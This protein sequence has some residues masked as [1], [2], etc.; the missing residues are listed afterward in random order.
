MDG[1]FVTSPT[2]F[3]TA[4]LKLQVWDLAVAIL[5]VLK[6]NVNVIGRD[7]GVGRSRGLGRSGPYTRPPV[8]LTDTN[9]PF[10]GGLEAA[11]Y[12][13]DKRDVHIPKTQCV[14][15]LIECALT[16]NYFLFGADFYLQVSGVAM[17][18]KMSPS[19]ASLYVGLFEQEV[20]FNKETNP[21]LDH[22]SHW[23]RYL[24]DIFFVWTGTETLLR[25]FH[26]FMNG[27]NEHLNFSLEFDAL[28]MNFLDILVLKE[29]DTLKTN[30]Y[31]KNTDKNSLLHG[32]SY[33]PTPLKKES[34][35]FSV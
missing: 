10:K 18:S 25:Q 2:G 12:F 22:I 24:D 26:E 34:P 33:H 14:L 1:A 17:G 7:G 9:V 21:F 28:K 8:G 23:R 6:P 30:L 35:H 16:S 29:G 19:F 32:D 31:R 4:V 27:K 11:E 3:W 15:D 20:I 13:L 5:T